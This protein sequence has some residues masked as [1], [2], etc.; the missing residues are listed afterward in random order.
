MT[1]TSIDWQELRRRIYAKAKAEKTWRFWGLYV[2]ICKMEILKAA[3]KMA[4]ENNGAPGEDG[5]TFE[6]IEREGLE[7]Y[8]EEIKQE[9]ENGTYTPRKYRE[10]EIP[11]GNGKT[12]T[13]K[14]PSIRDRIVEG[15]LKIVLEPIFEADF[16]E[17]SYGYRPKRK[18]HDAIKR[19]EQGIWKRLTRVLDIDLAKFFDNIRH[20][21]LLRKIAERVNDDRIMW[22]VK[23]ILKSAGKKGICQGS[24]ISPLFANLYLNEI[25][26]MLEKAKQ[27]TQ[28]EYQHVEYARFADD[29]VI[30]ID[31]HPK[32]D[33]LA[34]MIMNRL[35]EELD[36]IQVEM[37][38][39]K[40]QKYPHKN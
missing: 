7:N 28:D 5:V 19:V 25:D 29:L 27:V 6:Q 18:P 9:L 37:N 36:K 11:K 30:L 31:A 2:H 35:Q 12:R 1:K 10:K 39:E 4:K 8:L 14:I 23:R 15:A 22:L 34:R 16:Q 38:Q 33:G 26:K 13:L 40:L 3:Y 21:I 20:D 17:G 24:V 32:W